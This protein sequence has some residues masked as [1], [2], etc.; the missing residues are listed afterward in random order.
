MV[1]K[2]EETP[3]LNKLETCV[4]THNRFNTFMVLVFRDLNEAQ[5]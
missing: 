5:I 4:L 1:D 2:S 3:Q